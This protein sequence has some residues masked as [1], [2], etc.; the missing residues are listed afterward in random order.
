MSMLNA[1]LHGK[2]RTLPET[3]RPGES[4][5]SIFRRSEDL[6]T[7]TVF[8][9]LAYLNGEIFWEILRD[10][11]K[12]AI[13]PNRNLIVLD[14]IEFWPRWSQGSEI[15]GQ[16][17]EPDIFLR[18][19]VG[20]PVQRVHLIVECKLGGVQYPDQ[21]ARECIA[22]QKEFSKD[23]RPDDC[24]F[25]ALGGVTSPEATVTAF[26]QAITSKYGTRI[27]ATAADWSHVVRAL[28]N[29]KS[30]LPRDRQVIADLR[31]ALALYGYRHIE[32]LGDIAND[33]NRMK[34]AFVRSADAISS[35]LLPDSALER[36]PRFKDLLEWANKTSYL[37]PINSTGEVFAGWDVNH[38]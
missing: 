13:L 31:E 8:E 32:P 38:G 27:K 2:A 20:D 10:A 6:L 29:V 5:K 9:R 19:S 21:W 3:A 1:I 7:A 16:D 17:T 22:H 24:F 11:F 36:S 18:F 30:E 12:P 14:S 25:L 33:T 15:L 37:R 28:N 35:W 26:T 34:A 23:E 4:L